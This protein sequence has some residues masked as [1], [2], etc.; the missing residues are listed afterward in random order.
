MQRIR[1]D[2]TADDCDNM[3]MTATLQKVIEIGRIPVEAIA[4]KLPWGE[5]DST[6]DLDVYQNAAKMDSN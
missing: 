3:H 5:I 6:E 2:L 4:S 1:K